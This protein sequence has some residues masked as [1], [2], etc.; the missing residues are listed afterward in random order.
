MKKALLSVIFIF[1]LSSVTDAVAKPMSLSEVLLHTYNNN[2]S[3][4]AERAS[5]KA[6][7][8]NRMKV[9]GEG[10][11]PE[12]YGEYKN[13][14]SEQNYDRAEDYNT[15]AQE[16][17]INLEQPLFKSGRSI[18]NIKGAN[19]EI[20]EQKALVSAVEQQVMYEAIDSFISILRSEEI[21]KLSIENQNAL[22]KNHKYAIARNKVGQTT[23]AEVATAKARF[24]EAR[25]NV[26]KAKRNLL[27]AKANFEK[28]V[29]FPPEEIEKS[30]EINGIT[31]KFD[32]DNEEVINLKD[33]IIEDSLIKNPSLHLA[34]AKY[35]IEKNNVN[36]N[37]ADFFPTANLVASRA[38]GEDNARVV[39]QKRD[40]TSESVMISIKVPLFQAGSEYSNLKYSQN[41]LKKS[42]YDLK[43]TQNTIKEEASKAYD[44][45]VASKSI[46]E[47]TKIY[48]EAMD[49][50]LKSIST[51]ERYGRKTLIDVL[52]I[53]RE[54]HRAKIDMAIA[55]S[56]GILAFYKVK[57][58]L[59]ELNPEGLKL[60][61]KKLGYN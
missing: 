7:K 35:N 8:A 9:I 18:I 50:S 37:K 40:Y 29:G 60:V 1:A 22:E 58:S 38:R 52:D 10:F 42:K 31:L 27:F 24:F 33:K 20:D 26:D 53:R 32:Y 56:T 44:T 36:Y 39:N 55:E 2:E 14:N 57:Q 47:S 51:E 4:L 5:L 6:T 21:L 43:Y 12:V 30:K 13:S 59:G 11:M 17:S 25:S 3:I 48:V 49:L 46:V 15:D 34:K 61:N 16:T 45:F 41:K 23:I 54:Y 28:V 19:R